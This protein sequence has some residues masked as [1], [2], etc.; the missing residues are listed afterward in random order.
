MKKLSVILILV[1]SALM[2]KAG[3]E[4]TNYVTVNGKT[5]FCQTMKT[6]LLNMSLKLSEGTT[7]KVPFK[8]VDSYSLNGKLYERLPVMCKGAPANCT[9][10]MEYVT[11]RNGFRLYKFCKTQGHGEVCDGNFEK[12]HLEYIYFVF[13]DGK[14]YLPVTKDNMESILPFFGVK[15]LG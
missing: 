14:Y 7:M 11:S 2:L 9:A 6:G 13:K 12:A 1:L 10:L 15:I 8:N 5:Y 3:G 4:A